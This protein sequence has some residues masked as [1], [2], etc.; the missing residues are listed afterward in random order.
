MRGPLEIKRRFSFPPKTQEDMKIMK[1][2]EFLEIEV[3]D[4]PGSPEI[5]YSATIDPKA[6]RCC[7][8]FLKF[9][10]DCGDYETVNG[11]VG[12]IF[13]YSHEETT[14]LLFF[15]AS[16][17][18]LLIDQEGY[19]HLGTLPQYVG[20]NTLKFIETV[21]SDYYGFKIYEKERPGV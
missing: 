1:Y 17:K 4:D 7:P 21:L 12:K 6:V 2:T 9:I 8:E 5:F 11:L 20:I 15:M 16:D 19:V 14:D 3:Y 18:Q 10:K 13:R